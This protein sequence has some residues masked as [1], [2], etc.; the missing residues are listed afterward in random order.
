MNMRTEIA[1][2]LAASTAAGALGV[3]LIA[4]PA[5]AQGQGRDNRGGPQAGAAAGGGGEMRGGGG[6]EM[7]GGGGEMRRGQA[8]GGG[9]M[10]GNGG[11][12]VDAGTRSNLRAEGNVRTRGDVNVRN[13][14]D[15]RVQSRRDARIRG[16]A[17][18]NIRAG[19]SSDRRVAYRDDWRFRGDRW[20]FGDRGASFSVGVGI[21]DPYYAYGYDGGYYSYAASEPYVRRGFGD[22]YYAYGAAP[23]CTCAPGAAYAA[24]W[25]TGW[26][27]HGW[28]FSA[29]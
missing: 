7:R 29:W 18:T 2:K 3:L 19:I 15:V 10:R 26:R 27:G 28:G 23:G 5:L 17:D 16:T 21:S 6:A 1:R 8:R 24:S 14:S 13:R 25:D 20:R 9:E 11:A 22:G 12:R 4:A